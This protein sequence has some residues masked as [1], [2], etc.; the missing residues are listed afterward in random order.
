MEFH[1]FSSRRACRSGRARFRRSWRGSCSLQSRAEALFPDCSLASPATGASSPRRTRRLRAVPALSTFRMLA[2]DRDA[3]QAETHIGLASGLRGDLRPPPV[4]PCGKRRS[5]RRSRAGKSEED[6]PHQRRGDD[7]GRP[8]AELSDTRR[9]GSAHAR[10]STPRGEEAVFGRQS[11]A[12]RNAAKAQGAAT[13]GAGERPRPP[14]DA[15]STRGA[16][17]GSF[18]RRQRS[19]TF[20]AEPSRAGLRPEGVYAYAE[21]IRRAQSASRAAGPSAVGEGRRSRQLWSGS[22]VAAKSPAR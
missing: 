2:A 15:T 6:A 7:A 20:E 19:G 9:R 5:R 17:R 1:D 11:I 14:G 16:M 13:R 10:R 21:N 12:A 8:S 22:T 3:P 4:R 18:R